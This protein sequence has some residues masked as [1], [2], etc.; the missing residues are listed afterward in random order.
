MFFYTSKLLVYFTRPSNI[1]F[2]LALIGIVLLFTRYVKFGRRLLAGSV[3]VMTIAG[4][5]PLG[6]LMMVPLEN[7]FPAWD[8]ARGAPHGIIVLGGAI[9]PEISAARH[10]VALGGSAERMTEIAALAR[11]YPDAWIVFSGG[12]A[13]IFGGPR[14]ADFVTPLW[15]NFGVARGR[16][17][18]ERDSRTTAENAWMTKAL[19]QPRPGERWLLVTSSYHMP[20]AVGAFRRAGFEVEPYPVDWIS[21]GEPHLPGMPR[22]IAGGLNAIDTASHEWVGLLAYW[23]AGR[24]SELF[25][26][27]VRN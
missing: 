13:S 26:D 1:L 9:E 18:L 20:R 11:R 25:P 8:P 10:V 7:R 14:E 21:T 12:N 19:V 15:E 17:L 2:A 6:S 4:L 3:I 16:I 27:P 5:L 23:L 24:T 22:S